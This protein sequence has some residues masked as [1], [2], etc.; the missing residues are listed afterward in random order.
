MKL[1]GAFFALIAFAIFATHDV[2]IKILG[3]S[4]SPFQIAFFSTLFSFPLVTFML[5]RDDTVGT[6]K[7]RHPWWS[8]ARTIGAT[9]NTLCAFYAFSVLPLTEVYALI[10]ATPLVI[11]VLSIPLLGEKVGIHRWLA[12]IAG[13]IGVIVVLRPGSTDLTLGHLA[14]GSCAFFS[15]FVSIVVRKIG[16]E[17][18]TVVMML[19]PLVSNF[20]VLGLFMTITYEPMDIHEL[21]GIALVSALGFGAGLCLVTAYRLSEAAVVAP[22]QYSQIIWASLFGYLFFQEYIDLQTVLGASIIIFSGL[23]ILFRELTGG[24]SDNTP[25]L[26]NRS[27][28]SS[29]ASFRVSALL[30]KSRQ[31]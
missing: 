14:A 27:R 24:G 18:R 9:L 26:R 7:A 28:A 25:V 3:G 11:T 17:E 31:K 12:V 4:F 16:R 13:L 19:H 6:V 1:K 20:I 30:N 21:G 10:F 5:M 15:G 23:Y 29:A 22:M 8:F 2:I